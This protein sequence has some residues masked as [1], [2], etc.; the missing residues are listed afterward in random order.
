MG[1]TFIRGRRRERQ[2]KWKKG[3]TVQA[4]KRQCLLKMQIPYK[5]KQNVALHPK[6]NKERG[7]EKGREERGR[8][9]ANW[10][11]RKNTK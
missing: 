10:S 4:S 5:C 2:Q 11:N 7:R 6:G 8:K 1:S 3:D 9:I